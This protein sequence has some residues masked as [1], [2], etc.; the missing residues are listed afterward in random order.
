M[1]IVREK[2]PNRRR[3]ILIGLG[4]AVVLLLTLALSKLEPR[5]PG[6]DRA[7]LWID[8]VSRG[9][10]VREVKAPGALEPERMV[11]ISA[12]TAGR[13]EALPLRPGVTVEANTII[14]TLTNPDVDLQL[15]EA[16]RQLGAAQANLISL[17]SSLA[18]Q[19]LQRE[20]AVRALQTEHNTAQRDL[21]QYTALAEKNLASPNEI[22]LARDRADELAKRMAFEQ[23]QL[24]VLVQSIDAQIEQAQAQVRQMQGI[25]AFNM[26]RQASMNVRAGEAGVLQEL[27]LELGQ[28]VVPG[29]RLARVAQPGQLKAVLRVPETQAKDIAVGQN[30]KVD[31]VG[32][33]SMPGKVMRI[34]P[35]VQGGTVEVEVQLIGELPQGARADMNID[36][37][38]EIDRLENVL[39]VARPGY[40]QPESMIGIF[41]LEPDG[42][43]AER[44]Q[45]QLGRASVSTVEIRSGL[46]V[47]DRIIIS[48]MTQHDDVSRV[49]IQN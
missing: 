23:E 39:Y 29:Q 24:Q 6:V 21:K 37:T 45:V 1:D 33:G 15:L 4:T 47:G 35:I 18:Q 17:R 25:V 14:A 36:G 26:E 31:R 5:A 34:D 46:E 7:T 30:V 22:A 16:Q 48:D 32:S 3:P 20:S 40:G 44:V 12:V 28:W 43:H 13:V 42:K 2:K 10:M 38:I 11:I 19:R 49:R 8:S 9:E 27:P 41:R